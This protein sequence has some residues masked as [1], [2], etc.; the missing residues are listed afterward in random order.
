MNSSAQMG[1]PRRE[2]DDNNETVISQNL[3][4]FRPRECRDWVDHEKWIW[5]LHFIPAQLTE[6]NDDRDLGLKWLEIYNCRSQP[7]R[8][9]QQQA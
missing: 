8:M 5:F 6:R 3:D 2:Q 4:R 7:Q 1:H 9:W